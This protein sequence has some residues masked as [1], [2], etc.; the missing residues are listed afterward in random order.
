MERE[1]EMGE[2]RGSQH[3]PPP[4]IPMRWVLW[5]YEAET[6]FVASLPPAP[7]QGRTCC[8]EL[9]KV[10]VF[11]GLIQLCA[12]ESKPGY[13]VRGEGPLALGLG[14]QR[15]GSGPPV[16]TARARDTG[17]PKGS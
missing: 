10:G 15:R 16:S 13:R 3:P 6:F 7:G 14:A 4:S 2:A 11:L 12:A 5:I 1:R 8:L 17:V 9:G